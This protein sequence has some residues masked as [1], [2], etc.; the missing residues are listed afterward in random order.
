MRRFQLVRE[1][2]VTG[3]SGTGVVAE[4]IEWSDGSACVHW[5]VGE[6]H[7]WVVWASVGAVEQIHGHNGATRI[8][9]VDA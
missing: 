8:E 6:H 7:S 1:V 5:I 2:D 4:G 9:W 3:V